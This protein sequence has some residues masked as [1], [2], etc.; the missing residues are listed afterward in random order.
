[1]TSEDD[2]KGLVSLKFLRPCGAPFNMLLNLK[3]KNLILNFVEIRCCHL[4]EQ[5]VHEVRLSPTFAP[6]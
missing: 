5:R 4:L 1:M 2:I 6:P 3:E